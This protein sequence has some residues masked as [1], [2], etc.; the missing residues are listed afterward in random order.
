MSVHLARLK[1]LIPPPSKRKQFDWATAEKKLGVTLPS[2]YKQTVEIYSGG[3]FEDYLYLLEPDNEYYDL[4][5]LHEERVEAYESL[6]EWERKPVELEELGSRII[7]WATTDS[8]EYLFWLV[9][10]GWEHDSDR[11]TVLINEARG[12]RW[13]HFHMGSLAFFVQALERK[14]SSD[15]LWSRF[16]LRNHTFQQFIHP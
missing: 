14:V 3:Q 5:E 6:W 9:R 1:E 15:I 16:P 13:E 8:G 11:W 12:D 4:V 7:P 10:S 2:D